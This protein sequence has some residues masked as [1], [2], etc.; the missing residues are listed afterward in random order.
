[1]DDLRRRTISQSVNKSRA[2]SKAERN[3]RPPFA[4]ARTLPSSRVQ[5]VA[6]RLVSLQAV[7]RRTRA[8]AFSAGVGGVRVAGA[9]DLTPPPPSLGGKGEKPPSS[10]R[11]GGRGEWL[12]PSRAP[13]RV[14]TPDRFG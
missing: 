6:M 12:L 8:R 11:G 14:A 2:F 10:L 1:P 7:V 5:S 4:R 13:V 3:R 9:R